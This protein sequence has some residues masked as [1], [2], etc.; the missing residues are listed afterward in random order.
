MD[1][2]HKIGQELGELGAALGH[3]FVVLGQL[4]Q[5]LN[6]AMPLWPLVVVWVAWWLGAVNW[7]KVWPILARGAWAPVVL[8]I[9]LVTLVWSQLA[10][11]PGDLFGARL[12]NFWWQL[13]D[14]T[15]LTLSALLCGWLQGLLGWAPPEINLEPPPGAA[16][17]HG[18]QH[19]VGTLHGH[20]FAH[21]DEDETHP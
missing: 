9:L 17:T 20:D 18:H 2:W 13:G 5:H 1:A 14:V 15:L 8:V 12:D 11:A 16:V 7:R 4:L 19:P 6:E 10:P 21:S 3:V